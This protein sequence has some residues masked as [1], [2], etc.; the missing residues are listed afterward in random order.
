MIS[1]QKPGT[2]ESVYGVRDLTGSIAHWTV[3]ERNGGAQF[4]LKGGSWFAEHPKEACQAWAEE[5]LG[6]RD[7]RMDVG[8][9][10]VKPIFGREDLAGIV[11]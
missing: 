4:Q 1:L 6:P 9:R 2:N 11:E 7:K 5:W 3:T 10:C 8:F